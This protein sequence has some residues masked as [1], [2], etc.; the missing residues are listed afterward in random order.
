MRKNILFCISLFILALPLN[1]QIAQVKGKVVDENNETLP[2]VN[3]IIDI[4]ENLATQTDYDGNYSIALPA[5]KYVITYSYIGKE[6]Q[7]KE[8]NLI[9]RQG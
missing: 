1:A 4:N 9:G 8:V 2:G 6:N 5:G 7:T 3:V